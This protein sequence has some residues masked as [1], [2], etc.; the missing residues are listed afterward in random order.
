[1]E[2]YLFYT[3]KSSYLRSLPF[4]LV[5]FTNLT[6]ITLNCKPTDFLSHLPFPLNS[7]FHHS[8]RKLAHH[9]SKILCSF[10]WIEKQDYKEA[11]CEK[12]FAYLK[13]LFFTRYK[14]FP[15]KLQASE[16]HGQNPVSVASKISA[17]QVISIA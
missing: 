14:Q 13:N 12:K 6:V 8:F 16:G 10:A 3:N 1:M 17:S 7:Q 4:R 15:T 9:T 2:I 11:C 5:K